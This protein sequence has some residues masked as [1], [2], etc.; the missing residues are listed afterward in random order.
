MTEMVD[1]KPILF[2]L[3]TI[4]DWLPGLSANIP[5][6]DQDLTI[7]EDDWRQFEAVTAGLAF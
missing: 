5:R 2:S 7:N 6:K 4:N 1:Q 3:P